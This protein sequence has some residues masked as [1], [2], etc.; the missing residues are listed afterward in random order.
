MT[1]GVKPHISVCICTYKRSELLLRLL[2]TLALQQAGDAFTFSVVVADNDPDESAREVCASVKSSGAL[3]LVYASEP[4]PNIAR[5]RNAAL[6]HATGDY[7]AF[8]D[9]DEFPDS[10]WLAR[11]LHCCKQH[12]AAGVLGPVRPHFEQS[13]PAWVVVGRFCE[14]AEHPTGHPMTWSECRTGNVLLRMDILSRAVPPFNEKFSTGGEDSDFFL[15]MTSAGHVFR[16]CNEA[17]VYETVPPD[18]WRRSYM[19]KRAV[20][21]GSLT[22]KLPGSHWRYLVR[23]LIAVPAYLVIVPFAAAA[24]QHAWMK[25]CIRI[26]DHLGLLMAACGFHPVQER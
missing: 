6:R 23:A 9:D 18:R 26:C 12:Q 11:L 4:R 1:A 21:R 7:V 16:W 14:R 10:L 8:I 2:K 19:L 17:V 24:G 13:P 25:Y 22:I 3:S 15:R 20:L 5:A